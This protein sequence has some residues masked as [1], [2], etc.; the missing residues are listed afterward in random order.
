MIYTIALLVHLLDLSQQT[1]ISS[2]LSFFYAVYEQPFEEN[3]FL[4]IRLVHCG[5]LS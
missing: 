1:Y 2:L 5:R 3:V 4:N